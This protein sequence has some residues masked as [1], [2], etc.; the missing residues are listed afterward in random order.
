MIGKMHY[1][2]IKLYLSKEKKFM[3][4]DSIVKSINEETVILS[5]EAHS[6]LKLIDEKVF[7][8]EPK[9]EEI[10]TAR[11]A[12]FILFSAPGASGKTA[13]AKY[14]AYKKKCLYWDLSKIKLGENSFHGTLWRAIGQDKLSAFFEKI[15]SG[16][17]GLVLDAFDEAEMISGR[18]GIDFFLNDL[19]EVTQKSVL[20]TVCLFARTES[21]VYIAEYCKTHNINYAHYEIGFFEEYNAKRFIKEKLVLDGHRFT[22][23]VEHCIDEQFAIIRQLLGNVEVAR[24]FIG[25]AP[26]L[27]ALAKAFDEERN[28]IKL[29]EQLKGKSVT[30]TK[31]I[32]NILE[33]LLGRES[34]KVCKALQEKWKRKFPDFKEWEKIYTPTEQKVRLVE[35]ILFG[36][37]EVDSYY[38]FDELPEELYVEYMDV[39]KSFLPQHPFLQNIMKKRGADFTGPAFR[40]FTLAFILSVEEYEDLALQYF[41]DNTQE[42]H[43]P[44]QLLFDFY[45]RFADKKM[46]GNIFPLLYDSYKAKE[47]T[48]KVARIEISD[49]KE[50]IFVVFSFADMEPTEMWVSGNKRELYISRLSN[51]NVDIDGDICISDSNGSPRITN[52]TIICDRIIFSCKELV[53]EART[54]GEVLLASRNDAVNKTNEMMDIKIVSDSKDLIHISMPNINNYYKFRPYKYNYVE[55]NIDDFIGFYIFIRKI[56]SLLRKHEKDVPA[57][58]KEYIDN[59]IIHKN[60]SKNRIMQYLINKDIIFVDHTQAYLYKLH[61]E[62]LAE[63]GLSWATLEDKDT[64]K[65]L[66]EDYIEN[67]GA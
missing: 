36:D 26:V 65:R 38:T 55:E 60:E 17:T 41:R 1:D 62:K 4:I 39:V 40:D 27:E 44:S 8:I 50:N 15:N 5:S 33:F 23:T 54:P 19:N 64:F 49:D 30:G 35:Y 10:H 57:K 7:Y 9:Y 52:T 51:S 13:L 16:K 48:G 22:D 28:T 12:K 66:Y 18:A 37:V 31:I 63:Y 67:Y 43:F 34:E 47:T 32:Y 11:N 20:P 59:K 56:L 21:A 6:S 46:R 24:S 53:I 58:D 29:L 25:Y 61:T 45:V 14:I 42:F 2:M 3:T